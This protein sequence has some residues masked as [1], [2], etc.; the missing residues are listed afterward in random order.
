[1]PTQQE[2]DKLYMQTAMLHADMSKGVRLKVGSLLVTPSRIL[3]AGINGLPSA[4]G[5]VL[6]YWDGQELKTKSEVIHAEQACLN[7]AARQGVSVLAAKMYITHLPCKHCCAN[8]IASGIS[9]VIWKEPYRDAEGLSLLEAAGV[10]VRQ[11]KEEE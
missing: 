8:M 10:K 7:K 1:M 11:Y 6:E 2:D 9:E 3:I 5:N 4:L